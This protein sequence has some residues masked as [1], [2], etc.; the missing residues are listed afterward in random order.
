MTG[1]R[2][3]SRRPELEC[4]GEGVHCRCVPLRFRRDR[5]RM[6][7]TFDPSILGGEERACSTTF[8]AVACP[9]RR[10]PHH[11]DGLRDVGMGTDPRRPSI[12]GWGVDG[13]VGLAR[14]SGQNASGPLSLTILK[15]EGNVV[16]ASGS[17]RGGTR[18][19]QKATVEGNTF[20]FGN[21]TDIIEGTTMN[22]SNN[23]SNWSRPRRVRAR[24][25]PRALTADT[26]ISRARSRP[27]RASLNH[28][29]GRRED[30]R[31]VRL[32]TSRCEMG[33]GWQATG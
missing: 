33:S 19:F 4:E 8:S 17:S 1:Q 32:A 20:K 23:T 10:L 29:V 18:G 9:V 28:V 24:T 14:R 21:T 5:S 13:R 15:V 16:S 31:R 27:L 26:S 12:A 30:R 11:L 3:E 22:G 6:H 7:P 25:S 2:S